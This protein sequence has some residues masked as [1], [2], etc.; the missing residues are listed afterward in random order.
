L[1]AREPGD[2]KV[3]AKRRAFQEKLADLDPQRLVFV[4]KSGATT[5]MRRA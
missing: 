3:Q 4:E 1:R 5:A 2:P